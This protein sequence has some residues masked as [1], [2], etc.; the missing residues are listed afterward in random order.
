MMRNSIL[1]AACL[2]LYAALFSHSVLSS[3][4][5]RTITILT[6]DSFSVSKHVIEAFEQAH[7]A[8]VRLIKA[9]TA[10]AALDQALAFRRR[11]PAA[12]IVY[13]LDNT[14]MGRALEAGIFEP[15]ASPLLNQIP[16]EF[17][18]DPENRLLPVD[19]GDVCLNYDKKW[20]ARRGLA[21]P[22][23]L[24]DLTRPMYEGL[25]VV[26]NPMTSSPGLA[27]LLATI[28][29]FGED[30]FLDFW[31]DLRDN[32]LLVVDG[33]KQAYLGHFS[34]AS[35]GSRPIVIS[36]A[37][38]P[39]AEVFYAEHR[40][41]EAPSAAITDSGMS[42]R[43]VEF[44]GIVKGARNKELARRWVDYMLD[45]PFQKDIP[46]QMFVFP[47]NPKAPLPDLFTR[48][49][50]VARKPI[51]MPVEK[52]QKNRRKWVEAWSK[53]VLKHKP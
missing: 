27:F 52:I 28:A 3:E 17:K 22:G 18:L 12:D 7:Q 8:T 25:T 11:S 37:S 15:Y 1:L 45:T 33:W 48:Y 13:G 35:K 24:K 38:S 23:S 4:K 53:V 47:V 43:Q 51:Y 2:F 31:A 36:Y 40:I 44:V 41:Y 46:L 39:A 30:Q 14:M 21:P 26:E 32:D 16:Q 9:E 50:R 10:G 42:F 34:A 19:Y 6:H 20:F 29:H 5:P 49:A